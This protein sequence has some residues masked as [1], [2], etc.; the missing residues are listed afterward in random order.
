MFNSDRMFCHSSEKFNFVD[1]HFMFKAGD[2][3]RV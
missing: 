3:I 2:V 1:T